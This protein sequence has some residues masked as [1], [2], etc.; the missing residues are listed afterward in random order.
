MA[1]ALA[2]RRVESAS[3]PHLLW[4]RR[5]LNAEIARSCAS[6]AERRATPPGTAEGKAAVYLRATKRNNLREDQE[7]D[8][9]AERAT[10]DRTDNARHN[11]H[12][13][14]YIRNGRLGDLSYIGQRCT[15][16]CIRISNRRHTRRGRCFQQR[17]N[18]GKLGQNATPVYRAKTS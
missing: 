5:K 18:I 10:A 2:E 17:L 8:G 6:S 15:S 1:R 7:G 4:A 13:S 16:R 9:K 12:P 3:C 14:R 11:R